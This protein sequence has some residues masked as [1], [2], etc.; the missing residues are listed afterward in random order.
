MKQHPT[1]TVTHPELAKEWSERNF[2]FLAEDETAKSES[3]VW[4]RGSCGHEWLAPVRQRAGKETGCPYCKGRM[5]LKGFNDF[6]SNYPELVGEW[7]EKNDIKSDEVTC[8]STERIIWKCEKGH[9]WCTNVN[10]RTKGNGC[11]VC[12][13]E[14]V[15]PGVND[16]ATLYPWILG[17]WS[18]KNNVLPS[19]VKKSYRKQVILVCP[20]CRKEY[21]AQL[22]SR[23]DR[24]HRLC[25]YCS[26][27]KKKA[28]RNHE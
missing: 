27:Q 18:E 16:V 2:P 24:P 17:E 7:S 25:P 11:P 20:V 10:N 12:E 21:R 26:E 1:L 13:R 23:I 3:H 9:E 6:A 22:H 8:G 4:W 14:P 28:E 19:E 5:V 15:I